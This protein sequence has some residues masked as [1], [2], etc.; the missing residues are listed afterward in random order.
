MLIASPGAQLH[1]LIGAGARTGATALGQTRRVAR[2]VQLDVA[3][4]QSLRTI[5]RVSVRPFPALSVMRTLT[6]MTIRLPARRA[7]LTAARALAKSM[8]LAVAWPPSAMDFV[9]VGEVKVLAAVRPTLGTR[10][11]PRAAA[12]QGS[13]MHEIETV[14]VLPSFWGV[15]PESLAAGAVVSPAGGGGG[16]G[17]GGSGGGGGGGAG[18]GG[19]G[20]SAS[21]ASAADE[22][23]G[24]AGKSTLPSPSLSTR[25]EQ[26]GGG[27]LEVVALQDR[28]ALQAAGS[29]YV[30]WA[31]CG[32][33]NDPLNVMPENAVL[34]AWFEIGMPRG[35]LKLTVAKLQVL[36]G[37]VRLVVPV[38]ADP[39]A[40]TVKLIV[41][42]PDVVPL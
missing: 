7:R 23:P 32:T 38:M 40:D 35:L 19:G 17:G 12:R 29:L 5:F 1:A 25:S 37:S 11:L 21:S 9:V 3:R 31:L 14:T 18:G 10:M 15:T 39:S 28:G 22:Q 20:G 33:V 41:P 6:F 27:G 24:S 13:S 42:P 30:P 36:P 16:G 8:S 2:D 26:K 4:D 34:N